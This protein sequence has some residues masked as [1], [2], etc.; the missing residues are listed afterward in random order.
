[1]SLD[2]LGAYRDLCVILAGEDSAAVKYFDDIKTQ[3]RDERVIAD[4]GQMLQLIS[5]LLQ[6]TG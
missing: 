2:T 5:S 6:K 1:M 4:E 3:G